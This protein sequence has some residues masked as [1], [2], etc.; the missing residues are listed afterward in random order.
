MARARFLTCF[1]SALALAACLSAGP[2]AGAPRPKKGAKKLERYAP[3]FRLAVKEAIENGVRRLRDLQAEG[4]HWGDPKHE[5]AMGHTALPLLALL[6]A[7]VPYADPQVKKAFHVLDGM[8]LDRVYSVALYLMAIQAAHH[9][10]LDILDTDVGTQRSKRV[11]PK[12]VRAKLSKRE[13]QRVEAGLAYLLRA[14]NASGLWHYDVKKSPTETGHDLSN[15]QYAL[16]GLRAAVDMGFQVEPEVWRSALQGL[17]ALQDAKGPEIKLLEQR[18]HGEYVFQSKTRAYV[19]GFHY[20]DG[21]ANGPLGENTVWGRPATGSMTTAGIACVAICQEG[22]WRSR[23]FGGRDRKKTRSSIRGGL[24]WMQENFTV[25]ENPGHPNKAH[26]MYYVYGLERMGMLTGR[27]WIGTHDWYKEGADLLLGSQD[28]V[29]GGWGRH[30]DTS[31]GI[32]FLKRA[33][34]KRDIVVTTD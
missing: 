9:P 30:V 5:Q 32:L 28:A 24:A 12:E 6:K 10:K 14:Q 31:F 25:T 34:R 19:R 18:V 3:S 2:A 33:T 13:V 23:R 16:L 1:L 7:G 11:K 21:K 15:A 29:R 20:S 4:G 22:L 27:R 26:H 8:E 17:L